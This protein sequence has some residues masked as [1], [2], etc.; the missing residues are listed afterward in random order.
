MKYRILIADDE[1][2]QVDRIAHLLK[3][4]IKENLDITI[5]YGAH[6]EVLNKKYDIA[7]IDLNMP[8]DNDNSSD[9]TENAGKFV[10]NNL[11]KLNPDLFIIIRT[12]VSHI[13]TVANASNAAEKGAFR[14]ISKATNNEE[15]IIIAEVEKQINK[16]RKIYT[17]RIDFGS[18]SYV[19]K[20]DDK[21]II[22]DWKAYKHDQIYIN[23]DLI[24]L[25]L[26]RQKYVLYK[27]LVNKGQWIKDIDMLSYAGY[28]TDGYPE[29]IAKRFKENI[30][31]YFQF[32]KNTDL[33]FESKYNFAQHRL[34]MKSEKG[35]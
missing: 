18:L 33:E 20:V 10:I 4:Y 28:R 13:E 27:Y 29:E 9:D 3:K 26:G 21:Y 2:P 5:T 11:I 14:Y 35:R 32:L 8:Y 1:R 25:P 23:G 24:E 30:T 6:K 7:I 22:N 16:L 31:T 12:A 19:H 34:I 15:H 17:N